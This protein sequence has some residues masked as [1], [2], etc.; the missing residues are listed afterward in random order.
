MKYNL[1]HSDQFGFQKNSSTEMAISKVHQLLAEN[2][3]NNLVSCAIFLD[4]RKAF[5]SVNH[6]I[7]ITKLYNLGIRGVPLQL[8]ESFLSNRTQ[9]VTI[10]N[11]TSSS[12]S[13]ICG[14]PQGSVLGPLF[15]LCYINDLPSMSSFQTTLF[16]DD[17]CLIMSS[18]DAEM[19]QHRVNKELEK[20]SN[21]LSSNKTNFV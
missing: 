7:L 4:I 17:S 16:A 3:D 21:W 14:V 11:S 2:L 19:L 15:F 12:K 1:I 9:S 8:L 6:Q 10:N 20:I 5:D 18:P 13:T